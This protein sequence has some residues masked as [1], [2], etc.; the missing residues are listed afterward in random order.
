LI[1]LVEKNGSQNRVIFLGSLLAN[2]LINY[3]NAAD[4]F[5][6]PSKSEGLPNVLVEALL[7]GTPVVASRVG[8]IPTL[9]NEGKNGFL[10]SPNSVPDLENKLK[11]SLES[12]WDRLAIRESVSHLF[13]EKVI[14]KY[15]QIYRDV[16]NSV[17][18]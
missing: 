15:H 4:V 1:R 2:D 8:G 18:Q 17:K 6:L 7:C 16:S 9:V 12:D 5:C 14:E 3:Y 11:L 10:V 13:P